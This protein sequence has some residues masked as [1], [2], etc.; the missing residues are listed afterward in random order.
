MDNL[1]LN[2]VS[3]TFFR[4]SG[5]PAHNTTETQLLNENFGTN[6]TGTNVPVRC[7]PRSPDLTPQFFSLGRR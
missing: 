3:H 1:S 4:H 5:A 7:L 2:D 6:W